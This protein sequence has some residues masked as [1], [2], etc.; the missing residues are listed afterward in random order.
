MKRVLV[1]LVAGLALAGCA[2]RPNAIAASSVP[3]ETYLSLDC[4]Q[5]ARDL[6]AERQTLEAMAR[7]QNSAANADAIGVFMIGV[8]VASLT[9]GDNEGGIAL[10]KGKIQSLEAAQI[11]NKC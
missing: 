4:Q 8:P 11:R 9:N 1:V 3:V 5:I 10:S 6:A 2:K 7:Q